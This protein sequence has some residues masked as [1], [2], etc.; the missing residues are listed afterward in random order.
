M[1]VNHPKLTIARI[2]SRTPRH[3]HVTSV[4][5]SLHWLKI[6]ERTNLKS[7]IANL[8]RHTILPAKVPSP[9]LHHPATSLN[10][11]LLRSHSL[12]SPSHNSSQVLQPTHTPTLQI[13]SGTNFPL[14]SVHSQFL[15]QYTS[16][17]PPSFCLKLRYSSPQRLSTPN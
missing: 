3:H 12:P 17:H 2:V 16:T 14:N 11:I 5:K 10:S 9:T 6:A 13:D 4:L 15:H 7:P 8:Q 1:S